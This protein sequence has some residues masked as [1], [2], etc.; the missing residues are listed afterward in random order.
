MCRVVILPVLLRPPVFGLGTISACSGVDRV[1]S[2]KSATE[3]PRRP[4]EVGL[5]LRIAMFV[6]CCSGRRAREDVDPLAVR[7]GHD[8]PLGVGSLAEAGPGAAPLAR[9]VDRVHVEHADL[10]D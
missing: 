2:A 7:H 10:E 6:S 3:D 8:G 4:A 5:Y 9:A 1:I